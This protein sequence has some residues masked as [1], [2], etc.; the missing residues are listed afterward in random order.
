VCA[1]GNSWRRNDPAAVRRPIPTNLPTKERIMIPVL[2]ELLL[3]AHL[4]VGAEAAPYEPVNQPTAIAACT[5]EPLA[6]DLANCKASDFCCKPNP[7]TCN[8]S[9]K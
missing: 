1:T 7:C 4:T 9:C 8:G 3:A 6:G 5:I 2:A